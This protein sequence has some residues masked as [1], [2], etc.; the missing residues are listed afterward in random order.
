[1]P[2]E[3]LFVS[4]IKARFRADI[5]ARAIYGTPEVWRLPWASRYPNGESHPESQ[6]TPS[7][8]DSQPHCANI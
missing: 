7:S 1:M 5:R 2:S 6:R 8:G 4:R 3:R